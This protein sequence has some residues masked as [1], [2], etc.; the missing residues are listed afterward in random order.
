MVENREHPLVS[1]II[2]TYNN[3]RFLSE[4]L[5][6]ILHQ[7][8]GNFEI[9]L[10]DDG[11]T[12]DTEAVIQPY[13][14]S[15]RYFRK[16]NGGPSS[17]R[18]LALTQA[19]GE[20]IAFQDADDIWVKDK[21]ELQVDY[22]RQ[23]AHV[24]V[25]FTDSARFD[26]EGGFRPSFRET[27]GYVPNENI[28]EE[29]LVNHFIAMPSVMV[30]RR[31]L[32]EVGLFD[33]SLTGAEDYNLYL[34]LAK[35]YQF[36]FL[37]KVLVHVRLHGASLSDNLEQMCRDEIKNLDKIST[38][39]P[40]AA[41]PKRKLAGR[42]YARFGRYYF[43]QQRFAE[44]RRCFR[45]AFRHWPWQ[46]GSLP[47]FLIAALPDRLRHRVLSLNKSLKKLPLDF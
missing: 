10:V 44:A 38:M 15:L 7:T 23:N 36:G 12:D 14:E 19:R 16:A 46:A 18:N 35:K 22:L 1:V 20:F 37:D 34:R 3:A 6:S 45:Q 39:F 13:L 21:L 11:S 29:L 47:F 26:T 41:I 2:P 9:L 27:Y 17:A 30:R 32:D 42:I 43:S 25:V 5:D 33:E 8:Y 4:C 24:G 31:C 40:D 28:F